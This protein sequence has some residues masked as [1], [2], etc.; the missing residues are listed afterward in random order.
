MNEGKTMSDGP[1]AEDGTTEPHAGPAMAKARIETILADN[2]HAEDEDVVRHDDGLL[3]GDLRA[4]VAGCARTHEAKRPAIADRPVASA[5][6]DSNAVGPRP[7][8]DVLWNTVWQDVPY[9]RDDGWRIDTVEGTAGPF[10]RKVLALGWASAQETRRRRLV[11]IA[12]AIWP[13]R[14]SRAEEYVP[15]G[16]EAVD[17]LG[18]VTSASRVLATIDPDAAFDGSRTDA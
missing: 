2:P 11:A 14:W 6:D 12:I 5:E 13:L 4:I 17:F 8:S 18:S 10:E 15:D 16:T 1:H 9:V 3:F 7:C